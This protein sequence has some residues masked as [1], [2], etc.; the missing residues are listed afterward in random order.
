MERVIQLAASL[1][2]DSGKLKDLTGKLIK[3]LWENLHHP[4]LSYLGEEYRY[5]RADGS[6]N[7]SYSWLALYD[8]QPLTVLEHH[9]PKPRNGWEFLCADSYTNDISARRSA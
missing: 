9:V 3:N 4:P 7:V 2:E 5:R 1:P 6:H 8:M